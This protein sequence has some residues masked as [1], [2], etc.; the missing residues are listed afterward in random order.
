VKE[1]IYTIII[2]EAMDENCECPLCLIYDKLDQNSVEYFMGAAMMEP[3]VRIETNKKGFCG[4]HS[5]KML[6]LRNR[7][8][9]ALMLHTRLEKIIEDIEKSKSG[10]IKAKKLAENVSKTIDNATKSCAVCEKA[11]AQMNNCIDNFCY[12]LN[13]EP[14]F[15][16][17]FL[18]SKGLCLKHFKSV[19]ENLSSNKDLVNEIYSLEINNL[20]RLSSE[21]E[22]FTKMFDYKNKNAD[23]N[24]TEDSPERAIIKLT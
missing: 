13:T 19:V 4:Y 15:K 1:R 2:N 3:D 18:S 24:N 22:W 16:Q 14:D 7:L 20:K 6:K 11:N 12:L 10:I 8:S 9:L 21:V 17:R 23:W 5:D